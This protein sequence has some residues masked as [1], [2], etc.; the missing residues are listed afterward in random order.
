MT[1]RLRKLHLVIG[2][3]LAP[4]LAVQAVTGFILRRGNYAP[5]RWHNWQAVSHYVA[6]VLGVGLAFLVVSGS[7]LYVNMRIQQWRRLRKAARKRD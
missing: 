7:V 3:T 2:F 5:V 1:N 6:Y 4:L